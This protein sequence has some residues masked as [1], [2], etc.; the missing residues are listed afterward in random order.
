[1]NT[2]AATTTTTERELSFG[3]PQL[4]AT[5]V[6]DAED[7]LIEGRTM[8][9]NPSMT[10]VTVA[11]TPRKT[12][13]ALTSTVLAD[14]RI[15]RADTLILL[16]PGREE[17]G[18]ASLVDAPGWGHLADLL[19][20]QG[21]FPR[22]T[23]LYRSP[24]DEIGT[25][26][27]DAAHLLG[28]RETAVSLR[29]FTVRANLWFAPAGTDCVIHNEHDFIEVHTQVQGL[30]RMQRF[31][32]RDHASL[33][34]DVLMSPGYTTPDPFCAIGPQCTYH[35]PYH[36]YHADTDCVWLAVEY[37]PVPRAPRT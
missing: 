8:V 37:H 31:R 33:Y 18:E 28:E 27:F 34:Q 21:G 17:V 30:G 6:R 36:Q 16:R 25:V 10:A 29:E 26:V 14:T 19:G 1:M 23:P 9:V 5:L 32:D 12:I 24:Q 7:Y 11:E 4:R 13:P 35:Y 15:E 3:T 20:D 22:D 2:P